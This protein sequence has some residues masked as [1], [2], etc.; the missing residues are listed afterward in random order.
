ML[1]PD[2]DVTRSMQ[3]LRESSL[4]D[5]VIISL[6]LTDPDK[7]KKDLFAAVDQLAASL[8]TA[9]VHQG[10]DPGYP[11]PMPWTNSRSSAYA[12]QILGAG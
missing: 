6:A 4:S 2:K 11:W 8:A 1:P 3:F 12:P 9:V 7:D 5:K 10:R